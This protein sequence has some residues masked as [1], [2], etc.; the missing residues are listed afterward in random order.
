[1]RACGCANLSEFA[2]YIFDG[3]EGLQDDKGDEVLD[4]GRVLGSQFSVGLN[5]GNIQFRFSIF[6][7]N[8]SA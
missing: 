6:P 1:M 3:W 7:K 2:I 4:V 8:L 5:E